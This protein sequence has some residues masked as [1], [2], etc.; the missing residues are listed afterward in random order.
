MSRNVAFNNSKPGVIKLFIIKV[1][2]GNTGFTLVI[3][4][5]F[6][7]I[8]RILS[9]G[10]FIICSQG[11]KR[12]EGLL[13]R[14]TVHCKSLFFSIGNKLT[15]HVINCITKAAYFIPRFYFNIFSFKINFILCLPNHN[16]MLFQLLNRTDNKGCKQIGT[17]NSK[18]NGGGR[19]NQ[20]E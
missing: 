20:R 10:I 7:V 11:F 4:K 1:V 3:T 16:Y 17:N 9:K 12:Q 15:G 18:G 5:A 19:N 2:S 14:L 13:Y 6:K 8:I